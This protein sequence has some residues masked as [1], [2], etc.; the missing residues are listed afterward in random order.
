MQKE[1]NHNTNNESNDSLESL[2]II[3]TERGRALIVWHL[4]IVI[5]LN[6]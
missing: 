6:K 2:S 3:D 5:D 4:P 1:S